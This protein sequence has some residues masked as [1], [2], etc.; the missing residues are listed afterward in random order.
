MS[1]NNQF[2][3]LPTQ[4]SAFRIQKLWAH[5]MDP[6]RVVVECRGTH[7]FLFDA[8]A[9]FTCDVIHPPVPGCWVVVYTDGSTDVFTPMQFEERFV[10]GELDGSDIVDPT[11][12]LKH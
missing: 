3:S 2:V 11:P 1:E 5:P 8:D 9:R 10:E 6:E 12:E 4:V 7:P